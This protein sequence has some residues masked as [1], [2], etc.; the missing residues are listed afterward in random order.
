M[1]INYLIIILGIENQ[2]QLR[3]EPNTQ[4]NEAIIS[5]PMSSTSS[6]PNE[7]L[8]PDDASSPNEHSILRPFNGTQYEKYLIFL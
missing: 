8:Q 2:N 5:P 4:S 3:V 1:E 7:P 6:L